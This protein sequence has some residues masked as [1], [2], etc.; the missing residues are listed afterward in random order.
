MLR[1]FFTSSEVVRCAAVR[2]LNS[3]HDS[4]SACCTYGTCA[5][6]RHWPWTRATRHAR[7]RRWCGPHPR[8]LCCCAP[9]AGWGGQTAPCLLA[10]V[11]MCRYM[12]LCDLFGWSYP[13]LPPMSCLWRVPDAVCVPTA[14]SHHASM[15]RVSFSRGTTGILI[16]RACASLDIAA[17]LPRPMLPC[18][19]MSCVCVVPQVIRWWGSLV[20]W[21]TPRALMVRL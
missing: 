6:T 14:A 7:A 21:A 16:P 1:M 17:C 9:L 4:H 11:E 18:P 2:P 5:L 19:A 8:G 12:C 10:W 15:S 3:W 13:V 20:A